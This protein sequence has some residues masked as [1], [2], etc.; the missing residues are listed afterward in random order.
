[1]DKSDQKNIST[2][3]FYRLVFDYKDH[4]ILAQPKALAV[5]GHFKTQP[6]KREGVNN[7]QLF[8]QPLHTKK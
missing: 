6:T 4:R 8:R 2:Y 1:M 3:V 5:E 7:R